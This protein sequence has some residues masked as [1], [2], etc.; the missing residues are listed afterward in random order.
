MEAHPATV[1]G[2]VVA[3]QR[4][5]QLGGSAVY[6]QV[7][8][9]SKGDCRRSHIDLDRTVR[10][11]TETPELSSGSKCG[12]DGADREDRWKGGFLTDDLRPPSNSLGQADRPHELND[13]LTG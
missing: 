12:A 3:T 1:A 10:P 8:L 4:I 11:S 5:P 9:A 13:D 6:A 2:D 7:A